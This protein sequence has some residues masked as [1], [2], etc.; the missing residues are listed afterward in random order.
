MREGGTTVREVLVKAG[1]R[2][3]AGG[4]DWWRIPAIWRG[5]EDY[6]LAVNRHSGKWRLHST[7]ESGTWE[8]LQQLLGIN[9]DGTLPVPLRKDPAPFRTDSR[10][11]ALQLWSDAFPLRYPEEYRS[12]F[13]ALRKWRGAAWAYLGKRG[14]PLEAVG[15]YASDIRVIEDGEDAVLLLIPLRAPRD[16]QA[17]QGVQRI[18]ID[19]TGNKAPFLDK[20]GKPTEAKRMLGPRQM[21][22][23]STG[24]WLPALTDR[25]PE[26]VLLCEGPETAM[27]LHAF[28]DRPVWCLADAGGLL[29]AAL[30]YLEA[31]G[32]R[33][34]CVA[35]DHDSNQVGVVA[36]ADLA[37]RIRKEYPDWRVT[38]AL[39]PVRDTDWLDVLKEVGPEAARLVFQESVEPF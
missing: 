3:R 34:V 15:R 27:G 20:K 30:P 12:P 6:N 7:G 19:F 32:I 11:A 23:G 24:W 39:P 22:E 21:A 14:I 2:P 29:N 25:Y 10:K 17:L 35:G 36:A 8:E 13:P 33:S 38:V 16:D 18:R 4:S 9:G 26:R 1:I 37:L 28:T 31:R 5:S